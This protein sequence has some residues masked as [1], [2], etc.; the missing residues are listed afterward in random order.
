MIVKIAPLGQA[1]ETALILVVKN[2]TKGVELLVEDSADANVKLG[3]PYVR[4]SS[5]IKTP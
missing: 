4:Q 5:N 1:D 3:E 2:G